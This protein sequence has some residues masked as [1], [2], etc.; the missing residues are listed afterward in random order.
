[1]TTGV[2]SKILAARDEIVAGPTARAC[3]DQSFEPTFRIRG[4]E[5]ATRRASAAEA[6]VLVLL[7]PFLILCFGIAVAAIATLGA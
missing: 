5:T 3:N 6:T 7:L 4:I 1:M 2:R